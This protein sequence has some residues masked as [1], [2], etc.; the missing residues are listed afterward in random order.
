V[1]DAIIDPRTF[2]VIGV[3]VDEED[4]FL[5]RSVRA[6]IHDYGLHTYVARGGLRLRGLSAERRAKV[7][8]LAERLERLNE[9]LRVRKR[10][11]KLVTALST[12]IDCCKKLVPEA[13]STRV[14]DVA[15]R[16]ARKWLD[17]R[18]GDPRYVAAASIMLA[19]R[20]LGI[21]VVLKEMSAQLQRML[22]LERW[23]LERLFR[24]M[25]TELGRYVPPKPR[26]MIP[27]LASRMGVDSDVVN[28]AYQIVA[29]FEAL[30]PRFVQGRSPAAI[31]AAA[32][33]LAGILLGKRVPQT[34]TA[35]LTGVSEVAIRMRYREM[36]EHLDIEVVM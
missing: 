16:I 26:Q 21:P 6:Y 28:L 27:M 1:T 29:R 32:L 36:I 24:E 13:V 22:E 18:G 20:E 2:E 34:K 25:V 14:I 35:R 4:R 30:G 11:A 8:R 31:A 23:R 12:I 10:D 19:V 15:S 7:R 33:Y 5:D 3:Q 17:A 9:R